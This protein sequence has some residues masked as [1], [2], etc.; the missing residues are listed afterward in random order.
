[1][2]LVHLG[3]AKIFLDRDHLPRNNNFFEFYCVSEV[4]LVN[5][6]K[7]SA[8]MFYH[9]DALNFRFYFPNEDFKAFIDICF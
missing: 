4:L 6:W 1:M 5:E 2:R 8:F 7:A 9:R 3:K